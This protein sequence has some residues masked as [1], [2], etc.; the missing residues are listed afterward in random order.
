MIYTIEQKDWDRLAAASER[1]RNTPVM[2]IGGVDISRNA[3]E[4][5]SSIWNEIAMRMG[6]D[7]STARPH[8]E[9]KR[10]VSATP[11]A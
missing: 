3:H 7:A 10:Q 1:A 6:F 11:R 5:V 2:L 4:T 8:D 9:E